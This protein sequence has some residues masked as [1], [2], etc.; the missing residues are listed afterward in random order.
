MIVMTA[1]M[2]KMT[3]KLSPTSC[4]SS[5]AFLSA[6]AA[7]CC[8]AVGC[9]CGGGTVKVD[10][11]TNSNNCIS[12]PIHFPHFTILVFTTAITTIIIIIII[13]TIIAIIK[14]TI[15]IQV[16]TICC[17]GAHA[18]CNT[19]RISSSSSSWI[20]VIMMVMMMRL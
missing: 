6:T 9:C 11:F 1:I 15:I 18:S 16:I 3:M 12:S 17:K 10:H 8:K 5:C 4:S 13:I 19:G 7:N 20:I 2:M 14:I